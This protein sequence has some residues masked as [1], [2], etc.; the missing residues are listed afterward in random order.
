MKEIINKILSVLKYILF[1]I[2]LGLSL[3]ITLFMYKRIDKNITESLLTF[4]PYLVLFGLFIFNMILKHKQVNNL[5]YNVTCL[6]VFLVTII[7]DLRS[8]FDT[9]MV[10]NEI[11]GYRINFNFF[12]DYIPFMTVMMW[13][14]IVSN[15]FFILSKSNKKIARKIEK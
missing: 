12:S 9:N 10:L 7:V 15:V 1:F 11:M 13:G 14:L 8:L 2:A 3:Y 6:L 4:L 5:F